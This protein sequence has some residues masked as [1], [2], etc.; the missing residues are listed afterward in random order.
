MENSVVSTNQKAKYN[1]QRD[2]SLYSKFIRQVVVLQVTSRINTHHQYSL[3]P[4]LAITC[5]NFFTT[6][7]FNSF[8]VKR[9]PQH[10]SFNEDVPVP[11]RTR[12]KENK[13]Q[14]EQNQKKDTKR[15]NMEQEGGRRS[16]GTGNSGGTYEQRTLNG[17]RLLDHALFCVFLSC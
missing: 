5:W 15:N 16:K 13:G 1:S 17:R 11:K 4:S 7:V 9:K 3:T 8:L 12:V 2:P 14:R 6:L 10:N